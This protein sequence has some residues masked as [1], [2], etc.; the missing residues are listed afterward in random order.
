MVRRGPTAKFPSE[1]VEFPAALHSGADAYNLA[2]LHLY[3]LRTVVTGVL[4]ASC[5]S[6]V[7]RPELVEQ[8]G[9]CVARELIAK[10]CEP[11]CS[12]TAHEVCDGDA[13]SPSCICALGYSGIPCTWT[14]VLDD[15]G[16]E[17]EEAW[18]KKRGA[19]LLPNGVAFVAA[20]SV[21]EAGEV[22]QLVEMPSYEAGEPLVAEVT[23]RTQG[24]VYGLSIGFNLAWTQLPATSDDAWLTERVCLGEAAYGGPVLVQLGSREQHPSC[25]DEPE[26]D[27]RV[28]HVAIVVADPGECPAPGEVSNGTADEGGG[29]WRFEWTGAAYA[30][31]AEGVGRGGTSGVRLAREGIELAAAWIKVSVPS[32][33]SIPSPALRFWWKGTSG[34]PF[35]FEIGRYERITES[36]LPL[37]VAI[38]ND[39]D[40]NYV[41]CLPPWTHGNVVDLIFKALADSLDA[42]ELIIDDVEIVSD[43]RCGTST[44]LLDPGFEAGPT[45]IMGVTLFTLNQQITLPTNAELARTG[46]GVLELSYFNEDAVSQ[47]ET[48]VLVPPSNGDEG[49]AVVFWSNVPLA[50]EIPIQSVLGRAAINPADLPVGGGWRQNP[51]ICLPPEWS[52][53]WFRVQLRLGD[54]PPMPNRPVVPEIR[55]YID[56]LE[57]TTS[58]ACESE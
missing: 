31:F 45:R 46:E 43:E 49:P 1:R 7:C 21:C 27:I 25:F 33:E 3:S 26:G 8:A 40:V 54:F 42:S 11:T 10:P 38:G 55:I 48:W 22:S 56:D 12:P 36:S 44:D 52:G 28:D 47:W 18:T 41:Y 2:L 29:G 58:S 50:A 32:S 53:R 39:S 15:P 35:N 13:E 19:T 37:D 17:D 23:Y 16:F 57:L 4:V 34:R 6:P 5:S 14:G 9:R 20:I 24:S 51:P 30:G